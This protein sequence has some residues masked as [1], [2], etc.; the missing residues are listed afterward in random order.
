MKKNVILQKKIKTTCVKIT[1]KMERLEHLGR[2][3][4]SYIDS[5][6]NGEQNNG[7]EKVDFFEFAKT[8]IENMRSAGRS[9]KSCAN[10]E[11]AVRNLAKFVGRNTNLD[12]NEMTT[13][14]R[15][16]YHDW[17]M[18][19]KLGIRGQELYLVSIRAIF[20][21]VLSTFND[22]EIGRIQIR[23]NPF[24][25]FEIPQLKSISSAEKKA[26]PVDVLQ[27]IFTAPISTSREELARDIFLLSFCLCGINAVDLY[28]CDK[29]NG[30]QLIYFRSKTKDRRNDDAEMRI[31][32][33]KEVMYI[34]N[35]YRSG[36]VENEH[37]FSFSS[38]YL[39][40]DNFTKAINTGLKSIGKKLE[41]D[42]NISLYYARHSWATIAIN[43]IRLPEEVV[44]ECLVHAPVR[45]ML[46]R[47]V[48]RDWSR[49]DVTNRQV[50]DYVFYGKTPPKGSVSI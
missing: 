5:I 17:M 11:I 20:N 8:Y 31:S 1:Q 28:R 14:F 37:I 32:I 40:S 4:K 33:P 47:Y 42:E 2:E 39:E 46:H 30:T 25:N 44:D 48:K 43:D 26:L 19:S 3:L 9:E 49:I 6:L 13:D 10:Y 38:R 22:S 34:F 35:R 29:I 7:S 21:N 23:T 15:K 16:R 24:K 18:K 45:K 27:K 36:S 12:C 50:L 41:L